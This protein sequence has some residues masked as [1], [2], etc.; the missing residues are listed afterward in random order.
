MQMFDNGVESPLSQA[1][2]SSFVETGGL[3]SSG[4]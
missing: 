1:S 2:S 3:G 4:K